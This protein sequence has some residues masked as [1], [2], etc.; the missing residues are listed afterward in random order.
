M[1][2]DKYMT[3]NSEVP[4]VLSNDDDKILRSLSEITEIKESPPQMDV[5]AVLEEK[6][7]ATSVVFL[8]NN[9]VA[10]T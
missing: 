5:P 1:A 10:S 9:E 7:D 2:I 3:A 8:D 6:K 4:T